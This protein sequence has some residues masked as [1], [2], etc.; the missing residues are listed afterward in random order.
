MP[1]TD[2]H[3]RL[4]AE[5]D[6]LSSAKSGAD[7]K[8]VEVSPSSGSEPGEVRFEFHLY[9]GDV[10]TAFG[11]DADYVRES[12]Y[13]VLRG[14]EGSRIVTGFV[15]YGGTDLEILLR[16]IGKGYV[17]TLSSVTLR[18]AGSGDQSYRDGS[19]AE[20][21][22]AADSLGGTTY[23]LSSLAVTGILSSLDNLDNI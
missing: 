15:S 20:W 23:R 21:M 13:S 17:H 19:Y 10:I 11:L 2:I 16:Q 12:F 8:S 4:K 18:E 9:S 6:W 22:K 1:K 7:T 5:Y 14:D 3:D